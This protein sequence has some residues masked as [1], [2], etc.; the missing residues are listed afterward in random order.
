MK[1]NIGANHCGRPTQG[2]YTAA[3]IKLFV[4]N[5]QRGLP[6]KRVISRGDSRIA[7][8]HC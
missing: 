7:R 3:Q 8:K 1:P 6:M 5:L 2:D 4:I